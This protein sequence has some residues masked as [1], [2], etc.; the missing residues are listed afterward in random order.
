[1]PH[2][3]VRELSKGWTTVLHHDD[4]LVLSVFNQ[5]KSVALHVSSDGYG[6]GAKMG[7][8]ANF[9]RFLELDEGAVSLI[10]EIF[11]CEDIEK[12]ITLLEQL[13]EVQMWINYESFD[14]SIEENFQPEFNKSIVTDYIN[15]TKA[16]NKINN[17]T[18][19]RLRVEF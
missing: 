12:K 6:Y 3:I 15:E 16:A 11:K 18:K 7:N 8:S 5:G 14:Q 13:F 9:Q 2:C 10:K 1:M 19:L 4:I 17:K